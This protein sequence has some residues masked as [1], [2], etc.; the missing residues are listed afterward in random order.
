LRRGR[1][2]P[3]KL[4]TGDVLD[5]W[6]VLYASKKEGRLLLYAEM[7]LPG[8]AWLEF[9]IVKN[10]LYQRAVFRPKG[11]WGR[12]YWYAVLP[13]HSLIFNGLI[14]SITRP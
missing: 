9:R 6:R 11:L 1:T 3:T 5:F 14:K 12:L 2:H 10:K 4:Q 8:E 7:K 13:F